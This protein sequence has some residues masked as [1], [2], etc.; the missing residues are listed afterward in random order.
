MFSRRLANRECG[1]LSLPPAAVP[2]APGRAR[3]HK[4]N[5][6]RWPRCLLMRPPSWPA[7]CTCRPSTASYGLETVR[8]RFFNIFGPRQ[9]ADSPYSGVI[10]I[11][12]SLLAA[13][14]T[15]TI[16][17]DGLN[18]RDFV[19]VGNA[20]QALRKAAASPTASGQVYN[21]GT[22]RSIT[23]VEL[24]AAINALLGRSIAAAPCRSTG[25]RCPFVVCRHHPRPPRP[26]LR[27]RDFAGRGTREDAF[28]DA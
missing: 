4:T 5:W 2:M 20:V 15:P 21:I 25:R 11:F 9:R 12:L 13:G 14:K 17:G 28:V 10:A 6:C 7:K 26:R 16:Y 22:G 24:V 3:N 18:S 8:L 1:G 19:Y 23:L 27:A